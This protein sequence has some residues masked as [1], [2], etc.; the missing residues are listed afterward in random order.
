LIPLFDLH[1]DTLLELYKKKE[2][3]EDNSLHISLKKVQNFSKYL[4]IGAIWSDYRLTDDEAYF[5]C[6]DAIKYIQS[7]NINL[8]VNINDLY[9]YN[10][11]LGIEDSRLLNNDIQ[12][13]DFLH[14]LGVRILT[15]NWK[16]NSCIGGGW[17]TSLPLSDFGKKVILRA[18]E[19]GITIDVSHSSVETFWDVVALSEDLGFSPI[20]SHSNSNSICNHKRNLNDEQIKKICDLKGLIG[21]SLVPEHIGI[22]QDLDSILKH[23]DYFLKLGCLNSLCLGCDFDGTNTLPC[24]INSVEDLSL[25][26]YKIL[27]EFGKEIAIKIFFE[28]AFNFFEKNL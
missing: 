22:N 28:N 16:D 3:I 24:N 2:K 5:R 26:F 17:N 4:Q 15:L 10:F 12:R 20:A 27:N 11:I 6:L 1:C 8:A 25:L 18:F 13:L 14:S 23:I 19:L 21:I 7:Q 9:K